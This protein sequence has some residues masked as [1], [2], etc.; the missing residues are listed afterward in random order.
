MILGGSSIPRL[1]LGAKQFFRI[2]DL[3]RKLIDPEE[4]LGPEAEA[5]DRPPQFDEA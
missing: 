1:C 3:G 4:L 2:D 5:L